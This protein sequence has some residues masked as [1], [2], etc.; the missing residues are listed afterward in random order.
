MSLQSLNALLR[1]AAADDNTVAALQLMNAG[2]DPYDVDTKKK[3]AFN[4][5]ASNGLEVLNLMTE[6]AFRDTQLP[7]RQR[8]WP[9]YD[10]NTPSGIYKSTLI[11][12]AAKVSP[13]PLVREMIA[14]GAD[15]AIIN[16]SGWT[17]N[18]CTAVMP[19][20]REVLRTLRHEFLEK[21]RADLIAYRSTHRYETEYDGHHVV[22]EANLSAA[23]LCRAR[24]QQDPACPRELEEYL[25][26]L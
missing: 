16:G 14:A 22:Y 3:T 23:D 13:E 10:L 19:G 15:I 8:R 4:H 5:A 20:R 18:H 11:T 21:G 24:L 17:L 26:I 25:A 6:A 12:Y 9:E 7:L 2:A 1:K